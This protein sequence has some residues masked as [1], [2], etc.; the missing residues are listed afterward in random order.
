MIAT[1]GIATLREAIDIGNWIFFPNGPDL[2]C[3]DFA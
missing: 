1:C 3:S 2:R